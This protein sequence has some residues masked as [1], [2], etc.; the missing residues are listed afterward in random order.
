MLTLNSSWRCLILAHLLV[1]GCGGGGDSS[2]PAGS[3]P[4]TPSQSAPPPTS[5][6]APPPTSQS[7]PLPRVKSPV[8][9]C[10]AA[11]SSREGSSSGGIEGTGLRSTKGVVTA[12]GGNS[13]TVNEIVFDASHAV[14]FVNGVCATLADLRV[15]ATATVEGDVNDSTHSGTALT[16]YADESVAGAINSIDRT[17]GALT[18]NGQAVVVTSATLFGDDIQPAQLNTLR[19]GEMIAVS[20]SLRQDGTLVATR[21]HRWPA[22][23]YESV[24]GLVTSIDTTPGLL[25]VNGVQVRYTDSLLVGFSDGAIHI[26]DYIRALGQAL[27]DRDGYAGATGIDAVAI[28][29]AV[30]PAPDPR[31]DIVL[32][33]AVSAVRAADDFDVMGQPVKI[34]SSTRFAG[35]VTGW[36]DWFHSSPSGYFVTVFGSLDPSGYVVADLVVPQIVPDDLLT[37]PITAIDRAAR[38][39]DVMGIPVRFSGAYSYLEREGL[40]VNLDALNVGD[41]LAV[42]GQ[43]LDTGLVDVLMASQSAPSSEASIRG[44]GL[45]LFLP[46]HR[47]ILVMLDGIQAD[48]T[49]AQFFS[50]RENSPYSPSPADA[51]WNYYAKGWVSVQVEGVWTGVY[52]NASKVYWQDEMCCE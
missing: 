5:Q 9:D 43:A 36:T 18:V 25:E 45:N 46:S 50:R 13:L 39:V 33:G 42:E 34:Y 24:A 14:V 49:N 6:S 8:A 3:S 7:V 17:T 31:K 27:G 47:P 26:G 4:S 19:Q 21:I 16:I 40:A 20:G 37:G 30:V 1:S 2:P 32:A 38:T 23:A 29:R 51:F 48:T 11:S 10:L 28:Q 44:F 41:G 22:A 15:G 12:V 52:I 35:L